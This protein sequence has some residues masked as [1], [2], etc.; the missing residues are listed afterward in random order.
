MEKR[1]ETPTN[2]YFYEV[3]NNGQ[4]IF[5]RQKSK[6]TNQDKNS[7]TFRLNKQDPVAFIEKLINKLNKGLITWDVYDIN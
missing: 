6:L 4:E 1:F 7:G 3:V 5:V 2:I